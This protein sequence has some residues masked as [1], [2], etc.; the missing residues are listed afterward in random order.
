MCER[1]YPF[2]LKR[3]IDAGIEPVLLEETNDKSGFM[4]EIQ[5][6]GEMIYSADWHLEVVFCEV[7]Q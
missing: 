4:E 7:Q 2:R 6:S 3:E 1:F 5:K